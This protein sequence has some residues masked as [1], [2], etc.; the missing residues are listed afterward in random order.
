MTADDDVLEAQRR[1]AAFLAEND[2]E[3]PPA[4]RLLDLHSELGELAKEVAESTGYGND[5]D[6]V[7]VA[8]DEV[9]DALFALLAFSESVGIDADEALRVALEKYE[10][11]IEE[12]GA[13]SSGE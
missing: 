8:T 2:L 6:D 10:R 1:V 12:S 13:P 5:P 11:R 9:G 4:Y 3:A 7:E